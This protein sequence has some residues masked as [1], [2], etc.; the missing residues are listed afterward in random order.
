MQNA[1]FAMHNAECTMHNAQ[2][3]MHNAERLLDVKFM[4]FKF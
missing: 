3:R 1:Q 4:I 2:C